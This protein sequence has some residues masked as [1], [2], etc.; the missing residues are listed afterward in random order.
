MGTL[1]RWFNVVT[2]FAVVFGSAEALQYLEFLGPK[3]GTA[4]AGLAGLVNMFVRALPD[5]DKDGTPDLF[6]RGR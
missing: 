5:A 3:V 6:Q 2:A 4:I 1:P